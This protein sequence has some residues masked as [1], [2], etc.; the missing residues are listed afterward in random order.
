MPF[1]H[2]PHDRCHTGRQRGGDEV[3]RRKTFSLPL[4]VDRGIGGQLGSGRAVE[5]LAVKL[6][7]V[8]NGDFYGQGGSALSSARGAGPP[9]GGAQKEHDPGSSGS[10]EENLEKLEGH[11]ATLGLESLIRAGF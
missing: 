10:P 11:G 6:P 4:V 8:A 2:N 5:R 9:G 3:G 1:G 7:L